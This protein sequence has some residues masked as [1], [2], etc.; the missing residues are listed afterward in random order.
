MA[1][2]LHAPFGEVIDEGF[3]VFSVGAD[4]VAISSYTKQ[5]LDVLRGHLNSLPSTANSAIRSPYA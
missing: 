2:G 5:R 3:R 1:A 4:V